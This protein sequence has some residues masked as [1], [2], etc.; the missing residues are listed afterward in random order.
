MAR[1]DDAMARLLQ[2]AGLI[3]AG[4][5]GAAREQ[6]TRWGGRLHHVVVEM[7]FAREEHVAQAIAR[8]TNLP[9]VAL[10]TVP[11]DPAA[12]QRLDATLCEQ[13][14]VF[15]CALRDNGTTLWLAVSDPTDPELAQV[16]WKAGVGQVRPVIAGFDEIQDAILRTYRGETQRRW[17]TGE[18]FG[19]NVPPPPFATP[20]PLVTAPAVGGTP[21]PMPT[22]V[23]LPG[24]PGVMPATPG[25]PMP[26]A[27]GLAAPAAAAP[28]VA[29]PAG[30]PPVP[31]VPP[32]G[33]WPTP[34]ATP[35]GGWPT[36]PP[37]PTGTRLAAL[38]GSETISKSLDELLGLA[39]TGALSP[40]QLQR[41]AVL[42]ANQDRMA[43]VVR[44]VI[45]LCVERGM[46]SMDV[47]KGR[48][49]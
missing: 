45:E 31:P 3:D 28:V 12:L 18:A 35:S 2:G 8:G 7:G 46:F 27:P 48:L 22:A 15:P 21:A 44:T 43:R 36:P 41:L 5:L 20:A 16:A 47:F 25:T 49:R 9:R 11:P 42:K 17:G 30:F 37:E 24:A 38:A 33:G 29:V 23:A 14:N 32:S 4:Q 6:I 1:T 40:D 10:G 19:R 26:V 39:G 34:V 13:K